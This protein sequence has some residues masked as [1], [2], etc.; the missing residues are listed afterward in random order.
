MIE[1]GVFSLQQPNPESNNGG[2]S[3]PDMPVNGS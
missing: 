2:D 3:V 1:Q